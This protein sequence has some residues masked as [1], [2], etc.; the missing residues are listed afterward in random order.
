M[1]E[2]LSHSIFP[3]FSNVKADSCGYNYRFRKFWFSTF[4]ILTFELVSPSFGLLVSIRAIC[5]WNHAALV[6]LFDVYEMNEEFRVGPDYC[7]FFVKP[8]H[9]SGEE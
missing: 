8:A 1:L 4:Y 9:R 7:A 5:P 3:I 6:L 2:Y